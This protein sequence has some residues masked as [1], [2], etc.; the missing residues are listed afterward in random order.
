MRYVPGKVAPGRRN[1]RDARGGVTLVLVAISVTVLFMFGGFGMDFARMYAYKAQLKTLTDAASLAA[2][3]EKR[4]AGTEADAT[5]RAVALKSGN[6]VNGSA[7]AQLAD[8]NISYGTWDFTTKVFTATGNYT[9]ANAVRARARYT[10]DWTLARVFG[11]QTR[12]LVSESVAALGSLGTSQCLKPWAVPYSNML[13][14]LGRA[15]TDTGYRMTNADV[16][17]LRTN[18]TPIKFKISSGNTS[19]G[20]GTVGGTV[21]S[22]NYYAVKFGPVQYANGTSGT[23]N[24]GGNA[25]RDNVASLTCASTGTAGVDDWLDL[26]NG[27]MVGPTNQGLADLCGQNGNGNG[28][29]SC[30]KTIVVPIWST[31]SSPSANAWVRILYIGTFQLTGKNASDEIL[32]YLTALSTSP[33]TGFVPRPG[34]VSAAALVQ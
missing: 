1:Q 10:A 2:A 16:N 28:L 8:S 4:L 31:R 30:N 14:T 18:Q 11:A 22:G 20:D 21:I 6:K 9:T 25:Y 29:F 7:I 15:A 3:T 5:A 19:G 34:P 23:P 26:E 24:N 12:T 13:V 27:N 32:G 17:T 33:G